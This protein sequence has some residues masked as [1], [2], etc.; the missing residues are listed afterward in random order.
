M[1]FFILLSVDDERNAVEWI[2]VNKTLLADGGR[3]G[4][5]VLGG[6]N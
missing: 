1:N 6:V 4:K 5:G 3:G 2:A